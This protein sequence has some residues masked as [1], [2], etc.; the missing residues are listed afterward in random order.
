MNSNFTLIPV[1]DRESLLVVQRLAHEIWPAVFGPLLTPEQIDYMLQMMYDLE[2]L[3]Q[4][5]ISG[6]TILLA[7]EADRPVGYVTFGPDAEVETVKL[8]KLYLLAETRGRGYGR[9]M[10]EEVKNCA[11]GL[12][13]RRLQLSV[14][15]GN[16]TAIAAYNACGMEVVAELKTPIGEGYFMDDYVFGCEL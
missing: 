2:V 1:R 16:S 11:R 4:D 9:Q 8:H 10:I 6:V 14:N 3:E 12:G 7:C 13:Y 15:R 5:L